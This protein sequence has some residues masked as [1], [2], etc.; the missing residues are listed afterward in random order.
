M[1][2]V[3]KAQHTSDMKRGRLHGIECL[4]CSS[5]PGRGRPTKP[6]GIP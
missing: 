2:L 1:P 6:L 3:K 4:T 5:H